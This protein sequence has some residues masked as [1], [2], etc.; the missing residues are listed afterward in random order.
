[1]LLGL[2]MKFETQADERSCYRSLIRSDLLSKRRKDGVRPR[3]G[4]SDVVR[5]AAGVRSFLDLIEGKEQNA[6]STL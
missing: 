1:M 3:R 4:R 2:L 6:S 5:D